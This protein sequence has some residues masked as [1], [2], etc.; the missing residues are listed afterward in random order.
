MPV[1]YTVI[2]TLQRG[3]M[4]EILVAQMNDGSGTAESVVLKRLLA[5]LLSDEKY[6]KMFREEIEVM[7]RLDHR[8]IVRVIDLP[9][10][11]GKQ[12]LA[13]EYVRGVNVFHLLKR[14]RVQQIRIPP[15]LAIFIM[16]EVLE[17][18]DYAHS[19]LLPDGRPLEL[20][21]RDM[22][23]GNVLLSFDGDVKITDF[24]IAKSKM[25]HLST[26]V[27]VVKGTTRYLSPEQ[28]KGAAAT[29]R[30]DLFACGSLLAELLTGEP[31]FDRGT[32]PPTLLAIASGDRPPMIQHLPFHA[33]QLAAVLER[34]LSLMPGKRQE[35]ARVLSDDLMLAAHELGGLGD[36]SQ[37]AAFLRERFPEKQELYTAYLLELDDIAPPEE[38]RALATGAKPLDSSQFEMELPQLVLAEPAPPAQ[39][40][41][42]PPKSARSNMLIWLFVL[43]TIA[44]VIGVRF[45]AF[46]E[47]ER[48]VVEP[49][50]VPDPILP[51]PLLPDPIPPPPVVESVIEAP[52]LV[53]P[54]PEPSFI[55]LRR[56]KNARAYLDGKAIGRLP[57]SRFQVATGAHRLV[58]VKGKYRRVYTFEVKEGEKLN[59]SEGSGKR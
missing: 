42:L 46:D 4:G 9:I 45:L 8:N 7:S 51:D 35:S 3:G 13:M 54:A 22:T 5:D 40:D 24:G 39:T 52:P 15:P 37:L 6:V 43:G 50:I 19:F 36:R 21:H 41:V 49:I 1:E 48:V 55:E 12:C 31:L 59:L 28:I 57:L 26:T 27:G 16:R 32:V 53:A 17:G 25:S 14:C 11:D 58:V 30:S 29:T 33:P 10:V 18:L 23:P 56:P 47:P 20:V 44:G 34:V 38:V 2:E